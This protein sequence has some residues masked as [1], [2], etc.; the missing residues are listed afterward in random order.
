MGVEGFL[1]AV[2]EQIV[3]VVV[4]DEEA[5]RAYTRDWWPYLML[6]ERLGL[7]LVPPPAVLFPRSAEEVALI[8]KEAKSHGV[9]LVPRGGGSSVTGASAPGKCVV[10][11]LSKMREI[12]E[13]NEED[14]YVTTE[15]GLLLFELE[16]WL[17]RRGYTMRHMPQSFHIASVGG[18]IAT[19]SSGQY[20]TGYGNIED[21]VLS[22]EVALP[23]GKILKIGEPLSPRA[24]MG[25]PL[26]R[27]FVGS[28]AMFGVI[29]KATLRI[30]PI[31]PYRIGGSFL[32]KDFSAGLRY[33]RELM[34][35]GPRPQ[36]MRLSDETET[37]LRFGLSG[38]V[39]LLELEG[40]DED[41]VAISWEKV[42]NRALEMGSSDAG[43]EPLERWKRG[44]FE[45]LKDIEMLDSLN[46]WFETIDVASTW[47]RLARVHAAVSGAIASAGATSLCHAS[48]F[49][50]NGAALYFT[51]VF[52]KE[53]EEYSRVVRSALSAASEAGA[54]I[55]H[56]HGVGEL[57]REALQRDP[58]AKELLQRIKEALDPQEVLASKLS[59]RS[60]GIY[61]W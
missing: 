11:S 52:K 44:R 21:M 30:M 51:T 40:Y 31:P 24:S 42:R 20:S 12:V 38:A 46:L 19:A 16:E 17:N 55:S 14:L 35:R 37:S 39:M 1:R 49:Y 23:N 29:T 22:L 3:D 36:L 10:L 6:R 61:D 8:L 60:K 2:R 48:H 43:E 25:P 27:L 57:R 34:I 4:D 58:A 13:F 5:V 45:Y 7:S 28:E 59:L 9:C 15:A 47:S 53:A 50:L 54:V 41:L 56:H 26:S 32:F 33:A 18:A